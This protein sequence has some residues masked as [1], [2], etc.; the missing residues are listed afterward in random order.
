V[1]DHGLKMKHRQ[2]PI[3]WERHALIRQTLAYDRKLIRSVWSA[4]IF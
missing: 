3:R 2:T 1:V 4:D